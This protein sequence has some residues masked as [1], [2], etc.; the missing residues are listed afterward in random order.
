MKQEQPPGWANRFLRQFCHPDLLPDIEGDLHELYQ[1]WVEEYGVRRAKW[2]YALNVI[3]FFR[4]FAVKS[5]KNQAYYSTNNTAMFSN[6]FK[7]AYRNLLKSKVFSIVNLAGF[8][9]GFIPA[10]LIALYVIDELSFDAFHT[11]ADRIYRITETVR[12]ETG[13]RQLVGVATQV[14]PTAVES[15]PQVERAVR[16]TVQGRLTLGYEEFRDFED[17]WFADTTFFELFDFQFIAGDPAAAL[18]KPYSIV[19]TQTLAKKYFGDESPLG[20]SMR[21][22][23]FGTEATV[24]GV[25]EDFPSNSHLNP[26]LLFSASTILSANEADKEWAENDWSSTAFDTYL[27]LKPDA[28]PERLSWQLTSLANEHRPV[29]QQENQYHLQALTDIHFHSQHLEN[30]TNAH[31]SDIAY[32]YIFIAI[33]WLVLGIAFINYVNLSTARAMKRAKEVGLRKTVGA[34][35]MQLI[36]QFM[37]ESLL[38]V[39]LTLVVAIAFVQL[40]LPTF[41]ELTG[42]N[43]HFNLLEGPTLLVLIGVGLVSGV[44]AGAYPAFYLSRS[45]PTLILHQSSPRENTTLR[46]GLVV[47]QFAFAIFMIAAAA[48]IYQQMNFIRN[49]NMGYQREQLV[50]VDIN[51]QPMREKY[52]SVKAAFQR[53]PAVESV[54]ATNR[55]PGEWKGIPTASVKHENAL[56]EFLYFAGDEDFLPTY[57][58]QLREGQNFR[59]SKADSAKVL[60][61]ETA[62]QAMGLTNPVGQVIE[63]THFNEDVVDQPLRVE[64]IGVI[65]DVHFK[66]VHEKVAPTMIT[67]Y[68]NPLHAID[69]Y[70]LRIN[71]QNLT[72]TI[73]AIEAVTQQIDP[74]NPLEYHFLDDKFEELYATDTRNGEIFSIAASLAIFIACMGLFGLTNLSVEQRTKE[75]GIRKVLGAD[76]PHLTWLISRNFLKLVGIAFLLAAPVAWWSMNHWLQEFAYRI[77]VTWW[78]L[79]LAGF[80]TLLIALCTVVF[81]TVK[82]A[83]ANPVDSLRYE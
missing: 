14:G 56:V 82:V 78:V 17:A 60:L 63:I 75:V 43:L 73:A 72:N 13:E 42:K 19:L 70:T 16:L 48:I 81:Q 41:N 20:K 10:I 46:Q 2:R 22:S 50:T 53:I 31:K 9:L 38:T 21:A 80:F 3:T 47:G 33:G 6:Y 28:D 7:I 62:V 57:G 12:D 52:E 40:L 32:V 39:M 25:I 23:W 49:T 27:L 55:V 29:D 83:L 34:S 65:R 8:S 1:R 59:D 74:E 36:Y 54:T 11:N 30:D 58:I 76:V 24:T 79:G 37:S 67:Y 45:K 5:K 68:R 64:V 71:P 61:N 51:S 18:N 44:L 35:R 66:S 77:D 26:P 15:L 4:P 69:Y